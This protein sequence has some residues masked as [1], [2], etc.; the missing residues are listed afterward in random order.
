MLSYIEDGVLT[1]DILKSFNRWTEHLD[2][3]PLENPLSQLPGDIK[4]GY[5]KCKNALSSIGYYLDQF[6][7]KGGVLKSNS[8]YAIFYKGTRVR[9][10][11]VDPSNQFYW[12][13][14]KEIP[15]TTYSIHG[16]L[17]DCITFLESIDSQ[18]SR[19]RQNAN[20]EIS[21]NVKIIKL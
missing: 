18:P 13:F 20:A 15:T 8:N 7:K 5:I 11:S 9:V 19:N 4:Y 12:E 17:K 21:K 3:S 2:E 14:D 10:K 6:Y 16:T 1:N